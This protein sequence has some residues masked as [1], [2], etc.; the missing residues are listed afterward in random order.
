MVF[1][2]CHKYCCDLQ[3]AGRRFPDKF[4]FFGKTG[5]PDRQI[6][7]GSDVKMENET[8]YVSKTQKKKEAQSLQKL[9]ETLAGLPLHHLK[10]MDLP[11]KLRQALIEG[12]SI[13][14]NVAARRHRQYIGVLMRE[15]D[16]QGIQRQLEGLDDGPPQKSPESQEARAWM[17]RLLSFDPGA[18][19]ALL[20]AFP[21]MERQKVR[22]LLRNIKKDGKKS[23]KTR[24]TLENL[25]LD[26]LTL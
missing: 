15:A 19:E 5:Y 7:I 8:P 17:N 25:I 6:I 10:A 21:A 4:D 18:V 20:T 23:S 26:H 22:Q 11:E 1:P 16:P 14:A 9:G 13:T 12:K 3:L 24:K 2:C